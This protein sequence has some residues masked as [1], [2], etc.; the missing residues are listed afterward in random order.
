MI[1]QLNVR[2]ILY[3]FKAGG[4]TAF[5]SDSRV[6]ILIPQQVGE[7]LNKLGKYGV[8]KRNML[9]KSIALF[10]HF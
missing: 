9:E 8:F 5:V 10:W 1:Y 2:T 3:S 6:Y 4:L 7:I